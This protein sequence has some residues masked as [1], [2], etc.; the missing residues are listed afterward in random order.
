MILPTAL[1]AAFVIAFAGQVVKLCVDAAVQRDIGDETRGRVFA[2]YDM[3]FNITQAIA[4]ALAAAVIPPNGESG[5]AD[6][7]R[8]RAVP[9][10]AWPG[11]E[12][13]TALASGGPAPAG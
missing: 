2:L 3:L 5:H 6:R 7:R 10:W 8:D 1:V 9:G 4:V 13:V 11:F 12:L